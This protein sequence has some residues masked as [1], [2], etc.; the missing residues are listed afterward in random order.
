ML[1]PPF[2]VSINTLPPRSSLDRLIFP[3]HDTELRTNPFYTR[4]YVALRLP[5]RILL[6]RSLP[7]TKVARRSATTEFALKIQDTLLVK[8]AAVPHVSFREFTLRDKASD[9]A[10]QFPDDVHNES[11]RALIDGRYPCLI[12]ALV[13]S[14]TQIFFVIDNF[15]YVKYIGLRHT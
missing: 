6:C 11:G 4:R 15:A 14:S 5:Q 10:L 12:V 2:L 13:L 1:G 7:W 3:N 8:V 9:H